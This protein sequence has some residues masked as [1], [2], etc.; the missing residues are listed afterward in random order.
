MVLNV[1]DPLETHTLAVLCNAHLFCLV[2]FWLLCFVFF[3]FSFLLLSFFVFCFV[4]FCCFY[5][6]VSLCFCFCCFACLWC[7]F[8]CFCFQGDCKRKC[9]VLEISPGAPVPLMEPSLVGLIVRFIE[10]SRFL[11]E[12]VYLMLQY[13]YHFQKYSNVQVPTHCLE[14][15]V[16]T[17]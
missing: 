1:G 12:S 5:L 16:C 6:F 11:S 7:L 8:V 3:L 17:K 10:F 4:F 13:E 15:F 2:W 9:F 14:K